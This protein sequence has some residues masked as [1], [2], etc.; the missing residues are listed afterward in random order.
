MDHRRPAQG[1]RPATS[2]R[3]MR[4]VKAGSAGVLSACCLL[5]APGA[6][7]ANDSVTYFRI[8][9]GGSGGTYFPIGTI[10]ANAISRQKGAAPCER[11]GPCGVEGLIATAVTSEGSVQNVRD[12]RAG[13]VQAA[14]VQSDIAFW[15]FRGQ[16]QFEA[17]GRS[18]KLR[19]IANLYSEYLHLVVRQGAG[20]NRVADLRGK[21]VSLGERKSGTLVHA[22]IVLRAYGLGAG[23]LKSNYL[24]PSTSAQ[25][26]AEGKLDAFFLVAGFPATSVDT[27]AEQAKIRLLEISGGAADSIRGRYP[28]LTAAMLPKGA[29]GN[30]AAVKTLSVGAHLLVSADVDA[31]LVY[32]ITR[33]LWHPR[34]AKLLKDGHPAGSRIGLKRAVNGLN[35]PLHPGA[36]RYYREVKLIKTFGDEKPEKPAEKPKN[37]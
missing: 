30:N 19:V 29:Y 10:I 7:S 18:P 3:L 14:L 32:R 8:G 2:R 27:L 20:I 33:A 17:E 37:N 36:A 28:F 16:R 11:G 13:K 4:W 24:P 9:T 22:Q 12:L 31:E 23:D 6:A 34:T 35:L 21:R 26:L 15:A 25:S 1:L 5:V